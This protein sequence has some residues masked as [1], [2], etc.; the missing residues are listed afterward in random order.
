[1]TESE[2]LPKPA[3]DAGLAPLRHILFVVVAGVHKVWLI[4]WLLVQ[5]RYYKQFGGLT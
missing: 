4:A 1:M 5:R 2:T 3:F